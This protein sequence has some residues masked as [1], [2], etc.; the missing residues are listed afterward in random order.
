MEQ[1]VKYS[2]L[3]IVPLVET[4]AAQVTAAVL[5]KLAGQN[6]FDDGRK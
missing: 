4:G 5:K 2:C 6:L 1:S 3:Y